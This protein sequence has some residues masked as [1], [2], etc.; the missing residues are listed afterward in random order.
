MLPSNVLL[1]SRR[2]YRPEDEV[3]S[4]TGLVRAAGGVISRLN[5]KGDI[6]VLLI[7][8]RLHDDWTFPKGKVERG[9]TDELCALRE[10]RE[11][12]SLYCSLAHE[13]PT[14]SY[15]NRRGRPKVVRYWAMKVVRGEAQARN[16]IERVSWFAIDVALS[17]LTYSRDRDLLIAFSAL[18]LPTLLSFSKSAQGKTL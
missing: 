5:R 15:L 9:E 2:A 3:M 18:P 7:Y 10:V 6:E 4:V 14:V 12:T 8:R 13:L 11:E 16:E 1:S 17:R